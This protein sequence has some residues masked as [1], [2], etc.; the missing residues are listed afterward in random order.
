[1]YLTLA[2]DSGTKFG[3][4]AGPYT[5]H[6]AS[7]IHFP[8]EIAGPNCIKVEIIMLEQFVETVNF[9]FYRINNVV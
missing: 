3:S 1:M 5:L 7:S 6:S 2:L 9:F 8:H 4:L